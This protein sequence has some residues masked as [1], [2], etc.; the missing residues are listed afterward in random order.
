MYSSQ[1]Q[2]VCDFSGNTIILQT[3][4][5]ELRSDNRGRTVHETRV[6]DTGITINIKFCVEN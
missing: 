5:S 2:R 3:P 6:I 1:S 4:R